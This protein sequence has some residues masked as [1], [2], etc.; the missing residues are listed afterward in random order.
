MRSATNA[1]LTI[2]A[3]MSS[4]RFRAPARARVPD[5]DR[6]GDSKRECSYP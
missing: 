6:G 2:D 1:G 5:A 3:R 4:S